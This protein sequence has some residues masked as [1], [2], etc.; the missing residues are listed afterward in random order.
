MTIPGLICLMLYKN[1]Q[2]EA[3]I[4]V[5]GA[6]RLLQFETV[7]CWIGFGGASDFWRL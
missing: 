1:P 5:N 4:P 3:E 7:S 2:K 6:A